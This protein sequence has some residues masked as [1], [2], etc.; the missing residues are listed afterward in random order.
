[1]Y[2]IFKFPFPGND[3]VYYDSENRPPSE[4]DGLNENTPLLPEQQPPRNMGN[5]ITSIASID[6]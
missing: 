1:M 5:S 2:I 4:S 3:N 6:E